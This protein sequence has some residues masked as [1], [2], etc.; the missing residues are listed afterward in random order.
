MPDA[1]KSLAEIIKDIDFSSLDRELAWSLNSP[2]CLCP[3][4]YK[5]WLEW[6]KRLLGENDDYY[7]KR[8]KDEEFHREQKRIHRQLD[9]A[10]RVK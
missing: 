4:C 7:L 9:E 6:G 2:R 8:V 10:R 3:P 1:A 5:S